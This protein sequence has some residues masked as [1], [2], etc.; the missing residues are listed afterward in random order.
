MNPESIIILN[1]INQTEKDTYH[2]VSL[3]CICDILNAPPAKTKLTDIKKTNGCCKRW[4]V[5][6]G[7]RAE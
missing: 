5:G 4:E 1:E 3:T 7:G 6:S 2:M